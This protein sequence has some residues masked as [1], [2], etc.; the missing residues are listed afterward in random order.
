MTNRHDDTITARALEGQAAP[1]V[2]E[3]WTAEEIAALGSFR[4]IAGPEWTRW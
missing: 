3:E 1:Q 4:S 2:K